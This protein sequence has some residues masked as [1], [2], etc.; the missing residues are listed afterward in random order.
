[1]NT[2]IQNLPLIIS[3]TFI[4]QDTEARYCLNDLHKA[5]GN[6]NKHRPSLWLNNQQTKD[7]I[8]EIEK[9]GIPAF[10]SSESEISR[11]GIPALDAG[12]PASKIQAVLT[13]N[14]GNQQGTYVVKEL[15]YAYAMWISPAFSLK[16]I[17]AYDALVTS[18]H[19]DRDYNNLLDKFLALNNDHMALLREKISRFESAIRLRVNPRKCQPD[20]IAAALRCRQEGFS[21]RDIAELLGRSKESVN[22]M[23]RRAEGRS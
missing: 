9:A 11:A 16:V 21:Y 10:E 3:D 2:A 19:S 23:V 7:L 17:R 20:E 18:G 5:A 4:H 1:M 14:G 13:I 8:S 22:H 6:E 12:I 15:V